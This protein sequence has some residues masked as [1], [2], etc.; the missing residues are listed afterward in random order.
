MS[1]FND[2]QKLIDKFRDERNW[3]HYHNPKDCAMALVAEAV[4]VL[5]HFK[6]KTEKETEK[7]L[8]KEK[9]AVAEELV[10]VLYWVL[11]MAGD[12]KIDLISEFKEK[13]K[14]NER[15]YP[16]KKVKKEGQRLF[17]KKQD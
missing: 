1:I 5:E 4:E 3:R 6:W 17:L 10:D 11:L 9:K 16:I 13:M 12:L 8:K 2:L 7:Y 15:K 14:K